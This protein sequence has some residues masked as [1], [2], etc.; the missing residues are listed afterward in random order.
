MSD[1][2]LVVLLAF[3]SPFLWWAADSLFGI[4][5]VGPGGGF[6]EQHRV[7]GRESWSSRFLHTLPGKGVCPL[8]LFSFVAAS[9]W[10]RREKGKRS[11]QTD[12]QSLES[13]TG[14]WDKKPGLQKRDWDRKWS[15][16]TKDGL[17]NWEESRRHTDLTSWLQESRFFLDLEVEHR[18]GSMGGGKESE[19]L[20]TALA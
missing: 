1:D 9:K 7:R 5:L 15:G 10:M 18:D 16:K 4:G 11:R 12:W 13:G 8:G 2:D 17:E 14:C 20:G 19:H 3:F 6:F